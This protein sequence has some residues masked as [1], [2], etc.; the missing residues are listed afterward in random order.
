MVTPAERKN[1]VDRSIIVCG[2]G[3]SGTTI[4]GK[5]VASLETVDYFYEPLYLNSHLTS[6]STIDAN[7]W[8]SLFESYLY[9]ELLLNSLAG[10]NLNLNKNDDSS[11]Y[12]YK[13]PDLIDS[14]LAT[15]GRR[16]ELEETSM[17]ST[18]C[19]KLP[20]SLFLVP[21]LRTRYPGLR[22]VAMV[23]EFNDT[24]DSLIK[25]GW[26]SDATL[27]LGASGPMSAMHFTDN[28]RIPFWVKELEI[29]NWIELS[30]IDRTA[31][32]YLA[33]HR[34]ILNNIDSFYVVNY[35]TLIEEPSQVF[36]NLCTFFDL[37]AGRL[38]AKLLG[39]VSR[40]PKETENYK[41]KVSPVLLSF[42]E[43]ILQKLNFE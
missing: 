6:M 19:F 34:F 30:E 7:T 2:C 15:S 23:R 13:T 42:I 33:T 28:H 18:I 26:F 16:N 24:M 29:D 36:G 38:T 22:A 41:E 4:M 3:R 27:E 1:I 12:H 31:W 35:D 8:N 17:N 20:D 11:I 5:L 10:R 14:R 32:Y 21:E 40:R 39:E 25:K 9:E 37:R 43:D